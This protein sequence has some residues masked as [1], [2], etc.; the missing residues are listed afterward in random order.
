MQRRLKNE[1]QA[2]LK[3]EINNIK[4]KLY[5]DKKW[6]FNVKAPDNSIYENM[7]FDLELQFTDEYPYKPPIVT[8]ITPIYHP[9][10][11]NKGQICLD[12]LK[13]Q[14]SPILTVSKLLLS[15]ISLIA[16]PNP[17]DPLNVEAATLI[18]T[19]YDKFVE[20]VKNKL[21]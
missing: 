14:W 13:D 11:N 21:N 18:I 1:L 9:N 5:D 4:L 7:F 16:D 20:I 2:L 15:I 8:F 6:I 17:Y 19:N 3:N 10:I 12:I